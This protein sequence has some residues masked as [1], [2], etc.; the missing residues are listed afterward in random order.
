MAVSWLPEARDCPACG[1]EVHAML[2]RRG[3]ASHHAG[4]GVETGVAR[5]RA[6]HLVYQRPFLIPDGN[7]YD[8][9]SETAYF[10]AHP[11]PEREEEGRSL[12]RTTAARLGRKGRLLELGCGRGDLLR[13]AKQEGFEVF[14]VE[15]TPGYAAASPDL[16]IE[17]APVAVARSLEARYDA[18]WLAAILEHLYDPAPT[19]RR[20]A[21]ALVDGGVLFVDVPNECSLW[22]R[23]GNAYMRLRGRG[24]AV[25][26]SPTF[27]P[28]HVVGFCPRS[29]RRLLEATGFGEVEIRTP[30]WTNEMPRKPGI[31]ARVE[32]LAGSGVLALGARVGM[33]A[34]ITCWARKRAPGPAS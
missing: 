11:A 6:C 34:G 14:G 32:R 16:A 27:P 4:L 15:R 28:Y 18:I 30:R 10:H 13:G 24:W 2:G 21:T 20:V 3:G 25:N 29:L 23:V 19:L 33:G 9:H 26:L 7:P 8:D 17:V 31:G 1:S 5:C 12:A 22:T